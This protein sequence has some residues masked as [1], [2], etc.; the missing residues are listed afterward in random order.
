MGEREK[1]R[2]KKRERVMIRETETHL[3]SVALLRLLQRIICLFMRSSHFSQQTILL[4]KCL[5]D[6]ELGGQPTLP[7]RKILN[8]SLF[9]SSCTVKPPKAFPLFSSLLH[10]LNLSG[11][12][13][14]PSNRGSSGTA[15]RWDKCH[16]G[17][18]RFP[19]RIQ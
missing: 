6:V 13:V 12:S 7:R 11:Y 19:F 18:L 1:T 17:A 9:F 3:H 14:M 10:T 4:Y 15:T 5:S 16:A 2:E 8:V